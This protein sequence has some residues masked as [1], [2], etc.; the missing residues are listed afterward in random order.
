MAM[1]QA[2]R[3]VKS[4]VHAWRYEHC[5]YQGRTKGE[6]AIVRYCR[7]GKKQMAFVSKSRRWRHAS[8]AYDLS[9]LDD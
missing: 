9:H 3:K 8:K 7:C 1:K 4:C 2:E 6:I 5:I